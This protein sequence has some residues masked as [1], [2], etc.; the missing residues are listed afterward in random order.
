MKSQKKPVQSATGRQFYALVAKP[1][2]DITKLKPHTHAGATV[3]A[4]KKLKKATSGE[5]IAEVKRQGKLATTMPVEQ[6]IHY[7]LFD[8]AKRRG[9]LKVMPKRAA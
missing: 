6:A 1:K 9:V 3:L 2:V 5:V 8:L 4:I 7:Q